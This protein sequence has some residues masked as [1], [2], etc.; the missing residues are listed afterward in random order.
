GRSQRRMDAD[1]PVAEFVTESLHQDRPISRYDLG[2]FTLLGQVGHRVV[3]SPFIQSGLGKPGTGHTVVQSAQLPGEGPDR[4]TEFDRPRRRV[5]FPEGKSARQSGSGGHS[6]L[7]VGDVLNPPRTGAEGDDVPD[8][9][10]VDHLLVELADA[11]PATLAGC[12]VIADQMH[13]E[14]ATVRD[15]PTRGDR[16]TLAARPPF[17]PSGVAMPHQPGTQL[18]ELLRRI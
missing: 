10:L 12:V 5:P 15:G 3:D 1:L 6:Y 18:G 13:P 8:P 2:G 17:D 9:G 16:E 14:Q 11:G 7:V 4:Q